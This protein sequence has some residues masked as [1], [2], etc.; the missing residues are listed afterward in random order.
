MGTPMHHPEVSHLEE[1]RTGLLLSWPSTQL[2]GNSETH[3]QILLEFS[4]PLSHILPYTYTQNAF[5][6]YKSICNYL[7]LKFILHLF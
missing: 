1:E 7:I 6:F 2:P 4:A 5:F 3:T